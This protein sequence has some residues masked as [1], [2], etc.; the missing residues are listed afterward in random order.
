M[1]IHINRGAIR[2]A[3]I[4]NAALAA[5]CLVTL[6]QAAEPTAAAGADKPKRS[7]KKLTGAELYAIHCNRCHAERYPAEFTSRE[8]QT[9]MAQ[10]RVRANLPAT[11]AKEIL[12]YLKEESGNP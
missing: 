6:L 3:L 7:E 10:M 5:C 11:Q 9:I 1:H 8:W 4:A 2:F 12:K